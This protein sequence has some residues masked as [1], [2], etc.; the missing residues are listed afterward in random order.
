MI[1]GRHQIVMASHEE[2]QGAEKDLNH[3]LMIK[4]YLEGI[5][6]LRETLEAGDCRSELCKWVLERC[7]REHTDPIAALLGS[8]I[9]EDATYS[10]APIDIRNNRL[11]AIK[12]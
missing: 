7:R 12:V 6:A 8:T 4:A 1:Q 2:L 3:I 5:Q 11:W 10:K 9:E